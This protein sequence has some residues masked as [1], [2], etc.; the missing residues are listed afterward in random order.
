MALTP[1]QI[2]EKWLRNLSAS[3]QDAA[4]GVNAL[5]ENP[6]Q[7]AASKK[8]KMR[9]NLLAAIDSGKWE[10]G[11]LAVN[12]A[13][14]K[15]AYIEKGVPRMSQGAAASVGKMTAY[16]QQLLPYQDSLKSKISTM[17][18]LTLEDS[19]QRMLAWMRGMAE[20]KFR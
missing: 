18:D 7:K 8:A 9:Q 1:Q 6:M 13:D 12:F 5:Q 11:L 10:E 17:P 14:W 20:F 2:S 4:A 16:M 3:G 19:G 15:K